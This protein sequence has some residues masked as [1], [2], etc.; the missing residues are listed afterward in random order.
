MRKLL[1]ILSLILIPYCAI[2]ADTTG[3]QGVEAH[4]NQTGTLSCSI[5]TY[6]RHSL[7]VTGNLAITTTNWTSGKYQEAT[8]IIQNGG[9]YTFTIDGFSFP[10]LKTSGWDVVK[11][12]KVEGVTTVVGGIN[13]VLGEWSY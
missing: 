10:S 4:G 8:Y 11:L 2:G 9:A 3:M 5:A 6:Q 12:A 7:T 1:I 13:N